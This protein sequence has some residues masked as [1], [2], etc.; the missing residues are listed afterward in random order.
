MNIVWDCDFD[1]E[2]MSGL[3]WIKVG[4][5]FGFFK[6]MR[7]GFFEGWFGL[8]RSVLNLELDMRFVVDDGIVY[9]GKEVFVGILV[10]G[11]ELVDVRFVDLVD[12]LVDWFGSLDGIVI[13]RII[14]VV[15][16]VVYG[17]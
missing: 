6:V 11:V 4:V 1:F 17:D 9:Y 3:G 8:F 2:L 5:D 12:V 15:V 16:F 14:F 10:F 13:F 7:D